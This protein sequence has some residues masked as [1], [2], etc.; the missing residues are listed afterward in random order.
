MKTAR[1]VMLLVLCAA[2]LVS[3]TVMGTL[4]YLTST[5]EVTNTFT[6]GSVAI[7]LDE[8]DV[9]T[10][11]TA[12]EDAERVKANEYHLLPGHSYIKDPTIHVGSTSE[13]CFLFVKVVN[14]IAAIEA[15]GNTT[16]AYQMAAKGWKAVTDVDNTFVYVG[17][18]GATDPLAV[19]A[20]ANVPVF[21]TFKISGDVKNTEL[22]T[23]KKATITV[24]AY[25]VQKAGFENATAEKIWNDAF[26]G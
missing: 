10:D 17:A 6:V 25:A 24:T 8:A 1:K 22:D 7:T 16:V 3:A 15:E 20:K 11:G 18:E 23:Y 9:N 19:S 12:I 14:G 5:D 2:L 21:E 26:G 4:A 13:D